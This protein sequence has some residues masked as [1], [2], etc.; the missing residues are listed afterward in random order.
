MTMTHRMKQRRFLSHSS[1][2]CATT[3]LRSARHSGEILV[4]AALLLPENPTKH[5]MS[6]LNSTALLSLIS[7]FLLSHCVNGKAPGVVIL[8]AITPNCWSH[9]RQRPGCGWTSLCRNARGLDLMPRPPIPTGWL[10]H[11]PGGCS[12][13]NGVTAKLV[14][15]LKEHND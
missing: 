2:H 10:L 8:I 13:V 7:A 5:T 11:H 3:A 9:R 14:P 15:S 12:S 4:A 1:L 6:A